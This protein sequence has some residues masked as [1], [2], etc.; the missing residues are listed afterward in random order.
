[1][2]KIINLQNN[3]EI[4]EFI[5]SVKKGAIFAYPTEAVFGLGCDINN[6]YAIQKILNIKKRDI[7]KGLIVISDNLEKVRNLIDDN[8]FKIFV[9]ENSTSTPT[10]WLCP[11]SNLV[12]PEITG[13]SKKIA[14]RITK[15]DISKAICKLLDM[16]IIS[17]SANI[18]G[19]KP[20]TKQDGLKSF[21]DDIDY[22]VDGEVGNNKK[23]SRII[24][25]ISKEV[26]REGG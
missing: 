4:S 12:L 5:E 23:P 22:T 24:D 21:F 17:T 3:N 11:A 8:Y 14:I 19:E 13:D 26:I 20:V 1:M 18:A 2:S 25:L 6:K 15:H 16:P 9:E 10:T 7:S